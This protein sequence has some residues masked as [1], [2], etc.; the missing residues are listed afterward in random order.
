MSEK[1]KRKLIKAVF[2]LQNPSITIKAPRRYQAICW[3]WIDLKEKQPLRLEMRQVDLQEE[4]AAF[5]SGSDKPSA[6]LER[7][8]LKFHLFFHV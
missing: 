6:A 2:L 8:S 4:V 3:V 5:S 7:L 1:T